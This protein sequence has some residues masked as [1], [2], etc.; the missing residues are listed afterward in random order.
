MNHCIMKLL[1]VL[2]TNLV[3]T[4][5][6]ARETC[7][8]T[9]LTREQKLQLN[10]QANDHDNNS[11]VDYSDFAYD[12]NNNYDANNDGNITE[13]EWVKRW[14]CAFGDTEFYARYMFALLSGGESDIQAADFNV[15]PFSTTG[16]PL[17]GFVATN[18]QRY[19][20]FS[21]DN[22]VNTSL[23][24][25]QKLDRIMEDNDHNNDGKVTTSDVVHDLKNNYD[26]NDDGHVTKQEW[27]L[28]WICRLGDTVAYAAYVF[29]ELA[30]GADQIGTSGFTGE[31]FNTGVPDANFR[32]MNEKRNAIVRNWRAS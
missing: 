5:W 9:D 8:S 1:V 7:V 2:A 12:L 25:D 17:D 24:I 3:L 15:P 10:A 29:N 20:T 23:T 31:P 18:R 28:R 27:V 11:V 32:E 13:A 19:E 21:S 30:P 26:T 4:S 16:V 14:T 22:C 6:A